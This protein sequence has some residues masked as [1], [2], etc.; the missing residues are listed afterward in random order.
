MDRLMLPLSTNVMPKVSTN[1]SAS[2]G[3]SGGED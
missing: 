1:I 3:G 2:K